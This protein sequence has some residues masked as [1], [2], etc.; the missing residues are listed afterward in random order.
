MKSIFFVPVYNQ[1]EQLTDLLQELKLTPLP[2]DRLLLV[3]NGS[4]D[5]SRELIAD[6]GFPFL[7]LPRNLGV[8]Y[9]FIKAL[10]YALQEGFDIFGSLAGNGKMLPSEMGRV[11]KPILAGEADYVT[12]SR[13]LLGGEFPNLPLFRRVA[14]PLVNI[15]V[16]MTTGKRVTDATCGYRAFH[17]DIVRKAC[18]DWQAPW[19]YG[20]SFEYYLYAKILLSAEFSYRE[21]PITMRY[22]A[23]GKP[24]TK[25]R[26][27]VSWY[28]M[29]RPWVIAA[30]QGPGFQR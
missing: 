10:E 20:Y 14:I 15:F 13:F 11:L 16:W 27:F 7:D 5:G 26:A 9:S 2:C 25:M 1:A 24:Y 23:R 19:L 28:E 21:V 29:L 8:G 3:N 22:P 30:L 18:F 17:L 4:E 12:G 6:S